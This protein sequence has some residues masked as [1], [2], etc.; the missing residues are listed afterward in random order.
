LAGKSVHSARHW[1]LVIANRSRSHAVW[2]FAWDRLTHVQ[3]S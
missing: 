3:F 1:F 2:Q